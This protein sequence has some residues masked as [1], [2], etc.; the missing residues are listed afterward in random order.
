MKYIGQNCKKT[1]I[2]DI[3]ILCLTRPQKAGV[4]K[5]KPDGWQPY[6]GAGASREKLCPRGNF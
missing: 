5:L 1:D 6:T 3:Q 2:H 4:V